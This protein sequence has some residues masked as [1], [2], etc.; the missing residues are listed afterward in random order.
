M[1][2]MCI[3]QNPDLKVSVRGEVCLTVDGKKFHFRAFG[4]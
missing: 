2:V 4:W 1:I 3:K